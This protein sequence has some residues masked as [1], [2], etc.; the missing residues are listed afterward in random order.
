[1]VLLTDGLNDLGDAGSNDYTGVG[2]LDQ[3]RV[4]VGVAASRDERR[5]A[6]DARLTEL[7][8]NMKARGIVIYTIR[9][10]VAAGSDAAL[11]GCATRPEYYH[12]VRDADQL[13]A[14]FAKV[15]EGLIQLRLSR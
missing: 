1:V 5:I 11:K 4:G 2:R 6:L 12:D 10:E 13:P 15:G 8:A 7:C 3:E 14:V 9:V